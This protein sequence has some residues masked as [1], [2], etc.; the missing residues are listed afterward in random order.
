[1]KRIYLIPCLA[2]LMLS[3]I[4]MGCKKVIIDGQDTTLPTPPPPPPPPQ[5]QNLYVDANMNITIE[6]PMDFAL[7]NGE[8]YGQG[9]NGAN[10]K[11]EKINGPASYLLVSPD[12]AKTKV[13]NLEKGVYTFQLSATSNTGEI[14]TDTMTVVVQDA[15]SANKQIF[16]WSLNWSCP[17]GCGIY[18]ADALS[19]LPPNSSFTLYLRRE[20]SSNWE[21][22]VPESGSSTARF[23][24]SVSDDQ[25]M[26][27]DTSYIE[28]SDHPEI[29][30]VF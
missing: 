18:L 22:I 15:T 26:V 19:Y 23:V 1:M 12:S 28:S 8:V 17:F 27:Y 3:L 25:I 21:L 24:Y 2:V 11:W 13:S 20:F 7:L 16:F 9:R 5:Y 10:V 4:N 29:K 30:I 14:R 6:L